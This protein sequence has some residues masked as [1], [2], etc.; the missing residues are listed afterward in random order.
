MGGYNNVVRLFSFLYVAFSH[1]MI[2]LFRSKCRKNKQWS[3][4]GPVLFVLYTHPISE[5]VFCY[6]L[7]RHSFSDDN[8]LYKSGNITQLLKLFIQLSLVFLM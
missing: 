6:S 1:Y 2:F 8:Q 3:V 4:F 5:I 7:S